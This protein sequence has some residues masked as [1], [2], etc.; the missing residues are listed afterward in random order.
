MNLAIS[1]YQMLQGLVEG[2]RA[3]ITPHPPDRIERALNAMILDARNQHPNPQ[4]REEATRLI[5]Q[6]F[7]I[8]G[9]PYE[10][11]TEYI[12]HFHDRQAL[13]TVPAV[14]DVGALIRRLQAPVFMAKIHSFLGG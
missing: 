3:I 11:I 10:R 5:E 4:L 6:I 1:Y 8:E 12:Q 2:I 14:G 7:S 13:A 9:T